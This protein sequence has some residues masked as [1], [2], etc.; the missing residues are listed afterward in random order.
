MEDVN[1]C[2]SAVLDRLNSLLEP[3]GCLTI[4]E[5]GANADGSLFTIRP[6]K[7]FRLFFTMNPKNGVISRAMRNRGVEI[8]LMP[9]AEAEDW[10]IQ[11][12]LAMMS[13]VGITEMAMQ[14][15][16]MKFESHTEV[17]NISNLIANSFWTAQYV[18]HGFDKS[19][20]FCKSTRQVYKIASEEM[21][22][23]VTDLSA[24]VNSPKAYGI[25]F[26][27]PALNN[28]LIDDGYARLKQSC[29]F[30][31][32][33]TEVLKNHQNA[34]KVPAEDL[35]YFLRASDVD[36]KIS[37]GLTYSI[38][39]AYMLV[40]GMSVGIIQKVVAGVLKGVQWLEGK[41]LRL[42]KLNE[43]LAKTISE[44]PELLQLPWD[45]RW[46]G[47]D[48]AFIPVKNKSVTLLK[49]AFLLF[50]E[51]R[52]DLNN[53]AK[54][55]KRKE[56]V[57]VAEYSKAVQE[58]YLEDTLS[59]YPI[60]ARYNTI[61]DSFDD[62]I[63]SCLKTT[64]VTLDDK[65]MTWILNS[66]KWRFW[67]G[68]MAKSVLLS[69]SKRNV[70]EETLTQVEL[71]F[72]WFSKFVLNVDQI[73]EFNLPDNILKKYTIFAENLRQTLRTDV[74]VELLKMSSDFRRRLGHPPPDK[75]LPPE[76]SAMEV[77]EN[78]PDCT[79][80]PVILQTVLHRF[81]QYFHTRFIQ[82]SSRELCDFEGLLALFGPNTTP[83]R[84]LLEQYNSGTDKDIH[85]L[86]SEIMFHSLDILNS[87]HQFFDALE[88]K[89]KESYS[90]QIVMFHRPVWTSRIINFLFRSQEKWS[91]L[92]YKEAER[93]LRNL[94]STLI[95]QV[96][97]VSSP[98]MDPL[99]N[100]QVKLFAEL[101]RVENHLK[102]I[103]GSGDED[104]NAFLSRK[105]QETRSRL[106]KAFFEKVSTIIN[107]MTTIC[108]TC[109]SDYYTFGCLWS[110]IGYLELVV[111]EGSRVDP[112]RRKI[113]KVNCAKIEVQELEPEIQTFA[114]N[115]LITGT[116]SDHPYVLNLKASLESSKQ[117]VLKYNNLERVKRDP[118]KFKMLSKEVGAFISAAGQL[119]AFCS[120]V[121]NFLSESTFGQ[122]ELKSFWG[123]A[124]FIR[125][126]TLHFINVLKKGLV[127]FFGDLTYPLLAAAVQIEHGMNL[128]MSEI[129]RKPLPSEMQGLINSFCSY[130]TPEETERKHPFHILN[131]IPW[132]DRPKQVL[133]ENKLL[134]LFSACG[135]K[136]NEWLTFKTDEKYDELI[137]LFTIFVEFWKREEEKIRQKNLEE[138]SL[139]L[140]RGTKKCET[141]PEEEE[142]NE[143]QAK[144]FPTYEKDFEEGQSA[145]GVAESIAV[146]SPEQL[147]QVSNLHLRLVKEGARFSWIPNEGSN[148][149]QDYLT[150]LRLRYLLLSH[151]LPDISF[152]LEYTTDVKLLPGLLTLMHA[153]ESNLLSS[154]VALL[155]D[156]RIYDFYKD[157]N[158]PEAE[159]CLEILRDL[160]L[161]S[162]ELLNQWPEHPALVQMN[163]VIDRIMSFSIE[164]P[165]MKFLTGL[166]ILLQNCQHWE[167]VA[168]SGVSISEHLIR[169]TNLIIEWRK[170]E[171]QGWKCC[172][173]TARLRMKTNASKWWYHVWSLIEEYFS[174]EEKTT[175]SLP[176]VLQALYNF[177]ETSPIGEF[178]LRLDILLS[179][180]YHLTR[181][182]PCEKRDKL[183][184]A[185]WNLYSFYNQ[186]KSEVAKKLDNLSAPVVKKLKDY[187]SI[188]KWNDITYWSVKQAIEKSHRSLLKFIKEYEGIL[189]QPVQLSTIDPNPSTSGKG[190][191]V[192]IQDI[193]RF[194]KP[195]ESKD[196]KNLP[197]DVLSVTNPDKKFDKA[198]KF[199]TD[200]ILT[201]EYP[202]LIL[203]LEYLSEQIC[204]STEHFKDLDVD[205][206]KTKEQ[207]KSQAKSIVH[208]RRRALADLFKT[209]QLIGLSYRTGIVAKDF[210]VLDLCE[211]VPM[212]VNEEKISDRLSGE[213]YYLKTV[214]RRLVLENSLLTPSKDIGPAVIERLKGYAA[215]IMCLNKKQKF[216]LGKFEAAFRE[217]QQ[218][219]YTLTDLASAEAVAIPD[220]QHFSRR[221]NHLRH[222]INETLYTLD[223]FALILKSW[224]AEGDKMK[225]MNFLGAITPEVMISST[226]E[227]TYISTLRKFE[228]IHESVKKL[229]NSLKRIVEN[230]TEFSI[231]F[232]GES[233]SICKNNLILYYLKH[234]EK[235]NLIVEEFRNVIENIREFKL[236]FVSE[237]AGNCL[238]DSLDSIE[239]FA[240][241]R[242]DIP[243]SLPD[244]ETAEAFDKD[245]NALVENILLTIQ[246]FLKKL[247]D[248]REN[249]PEVTPAVEDTEAEDEEDDAGELLEN[250]LNKR[251]VESL[252]SDLQD[253]NIDHIN[254]LLLSVVRDL[255]AVATQKEFFTLTGNSL[256][257]LN[258]AL[259]FVK[260][261]SLLCSYFLEQ[262]RLCYR[263][264]NKLSSILIGTFIQVAQKGYCIPPEYEEEEGEGVGNQGGGGMGL[265]EGEGKTDVSDRIESEDQLEGAEQQGKE[266]EKQEDRD[267]K[268]EEN[269]IEMSE[270]FEGKTQDIDKKNEGDESDDQEDEEE[271]DV[272]EMGETEEGADKL[273]KELWSSDEE[274]EEGEEE[275]EKKEETGPGEG[276]QKLEDKY[277][278]NENGGE[279]DDD[280]DVDEKKEKKKED[281]DEINEQEDNS[282][283]IDPYHGHHPPEPEPEPL[284]LP[285]NFNLDNDEEG[286]QEDGDQNPLEIDA[287]KE[288][289]PP[290]EEEQGKDEEKPEEKNEEMEED[291][292][293][294]EG[295]EENGAE[296]QEETMEVDE[297]GEEKMDDTEIEKKES[298]PEEENPEEQPQEE[299]EKMENQPKDFEPSDDTPST[300]PAQPAPESEK[301]E[302][303]SK[304]QVVG[305]SKQ[306]EFE[307]KAQE[308]TEKPRDESKGTGQAEVENMNEGHE[309]GASNKEK[310]QPGQYKDEKENKRKQE[311]PGKSD[312]DRTLAEND[313]SIRK[314]FRTM[315][316]LEEEK[317]RPEHDE[318]MEEESEL[319]QH[320]KEDVEKASQVVDAAT[321]EQAE[322][323]AVPNKEEEEAEKL[324]EDEDV[325]MDVSEEK[326]EKEEVDEMHSSEGQKIKDMKK[327]QP[328]DQNEEESEE[329]Q[330]QIEGE[331]VETMTVERGPE[332]TYHTNPVPLAEETVHPLQAEEVEAMRV[333]IQEQLQAINQNESPSQESVQAWQ[334]IN[335][336]VDDLSRDLTE[337]LRLILEPT[338][339]TRLKGDYRTGRR[340]NMRKIISYIAS[341]FRKDNIWLRRTKPWKRDHEIVLAIDDSSSMAHNNSKELAFESLALVSKA[342]G[343]LEA[344]QLGVLSFGEKTKVVHRLGDPFTDETGAKL[345][346]EFTFCQNK[347][348]I[349]EMLEVSSSMM[350]RGKRKGE[351]SQLL[352]II[353]DGRGVF[354]E[355]LEKVKLAVR[356]ATDQ[357]IFIVFVI[358]DEPMSKD[359]IMDI[360]MP[361]FKDGKFLGIKS[362]L[363][364]FPFPYYLILRDINALPCTLGDALRQWF[365]L[366]T[367]TNPN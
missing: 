154:E 290:D 236:A 329:A 93:D 6:H 66:F 359:S 288:V 347:T 148:L 118:E 92:Q 316:K 42:S 326:E 317:D 194:L 109:R 198:K 120:G 234:V 339:A 216:N 319:Y 298:A 153:K 349:S 67:L 344:G 130:P 75:Y 182:A 345:L 250:H 85:H 48:N 365:Q 260:Q 81:I 224:S 32:F 315:D 143:E 191:N 264:S 164:S 259:P 219:E 149:S 244:V 73:A 7:D 55:L 22:Q 138:E 356:R 187:V 23:L 3:D 235:F 289:K 190:Q 267:C 43:T 88:D 11:D 272:K 150:P 274:G 271:P 212:T 53:L 229:D 163:V 131:A 208:Q 331:N 96:S 285:D 105:S 68:T 104:L 166:E 355:G 218:L 241:E 134:L 330:K 320:M 310:L 158:V 232:A 299:E 4:G 343:L 302:L 325:A 171:L 34:E 233:V 268:E 106:E 110:L 262:Q 124:R 227:D 276:K 173:E 145:D 261:Y 36:L 186:Y 361:E 13:D 197:K 278:G 294:D 265:G 167:S 327:A 97:L 50:R 84:T 202:N 237:R 146:I 103:L 301:D 306:P 122:R 79:G 358:V 40:S 16:L 364:E 78:P 205:R 169:L 252:D 119:V 47:D 35:A 351:V 222:K 203:Q 228:A 307:T 83:I 270:D 71:Y 277:A 240:C 286:D 61:L 242:F 14:T 313:L 21:L 308:V 175:G 100:E 136:C 195:I 189:K 273:E 107:S 147:S 128:I 37:D 184:I 94:F 126:K 231:K 162:L 52:D 281:I 196:L 115:S 350:T 314:K 117:K 39:Y 98:E 284:E 215:H 139:Y 341:E 70:N 86:C 221:L 337:Q 144:L 133:E 44:V 230:E 324:Q 141:T 132:S 287:M 180:H 296:K 217:F 280:K 176:E 303:A 255:A 300:Q 121:H 275:K 245:V 72:I 323:Q 101:A 254:N 1:L 129:L 41:G 263:S 342:L 170:L 282:D 137:G 5:R 45:S 24:S 102:Q 311:K 253:L 17:P 49:F 333:Q 152:N 123:K 28:F 108:K 54:S 80:D 348:L 181:L 8:F 156:N 58:G 258:C 142:L 257:S 12:R 207:Q 19:E 127:D 113:L 82:R 60:M 291:S 151:L 209:L 321:K 160:K 357:G 366:V 292:S 165:L 204:E 360:R 111:L 334:L 201:A 168:H 220:Q 214:S 174:N 336:V 309:V 25:S 87:D 63:T 95:P 89:E 297:E 112:I 30:M 332:T 293:G 346:K 266:K 46:Y 183:A 172:F 161:K 256:R 74:S 10:P 304:D 29:G 322:K 225:K 305:S 239:K 9:D 318:E 211:T 213:D 59:D 363:E 223:Q 135:I 335:S 328:S 31:L 177:I 57:T 179:F 238:A 157:K 206:T 99:K 116:I 15:A 210:G 192:I 77:V 248:A 38:L 62:L 226:F 188:A 159:K 140:K 33:L 56:N 76:E 295:G 269:G 90:R 2:S 200:I 178:D 353:S 338:K 26:A 243:S 362:Y 247:K 155:E 199:C 20:A 18:H 64:D 91:M 340:I 185:F 114:L 354:S 249:E 27:R 312:E 125:N 352:I 283:Q 65:M 367:S 279:N 246:K 193:N 69:G 251:L 51:S